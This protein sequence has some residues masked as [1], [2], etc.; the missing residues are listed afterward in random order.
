M[1]SM[2]MVMV[3]L[4]PFKVILLIFLLVQNGSVYTA[5]ELP[6]KRIATS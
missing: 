1:F 5:A 4:S 2:F 6:C 3:A